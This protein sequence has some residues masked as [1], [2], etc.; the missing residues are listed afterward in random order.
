[1]K[2]KP[3]T[4]RRPTQEEGRREL[5]RSAGRKSTGKKREFQTGGITP[6]S[7]RR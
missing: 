1:M 5:R 3:E 7:F 6:I 4:A 2:A